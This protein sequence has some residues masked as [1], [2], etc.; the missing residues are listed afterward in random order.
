MNLINAVLVLLNVVW[1][2]ALITGVIFG[3]ALLLTLFSRFFSNTFFWFYMGVVSIIF[4]GRWIL[5]KFLAII[6]PTEKRRERAL[7]ARM[8][9]IYK[10]INRV[11]DELKNGDSRICEE[12]GFLV[13]S[14]YYCPM[15]GAEDKNKRRIIDEFVSST[16]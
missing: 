6:I 7:A 16:Y 15:C 12:C 11:M 9:W 3:I 13:P 14:E 1:A 4:H 8:H 2:I 5:Y 10:G